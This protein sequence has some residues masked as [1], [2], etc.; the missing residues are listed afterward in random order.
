MWPITFLL[1]AQAMTGSKGLSGQQYSG[2]GTIGN[3]LSYLGLDRGAYISFA[4]SINGN[5][6]K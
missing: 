4:P 1:V 2:G 5:D 3:E 6:G